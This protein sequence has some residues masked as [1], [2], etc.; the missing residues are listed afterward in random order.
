VA[1]T[2]DGEVFTFGSSSYGQLGHGDAEGMAFPMVVEKLLGEGMC[3]TDAAC[4]W[5]HTII[6]LS[7]GEM[8]T[9]GHGGYGQLGHGNTLNQMSPKGVASLRSQK[10]VF[11]NAGA[12]HT[13]AI[14]DEGGTTLSPEQQDS[15]SDPSLPAAVDPIPSAGRYGLS[16]MPN[17]TTPTT[18]TE[19]DDLFAMRQDSPQ[20]WAA[21]VASK[22]ESP[23]SNEVMEEAV[24]SVEEV[25]EG[26][27]DMSGKE[28]FRDDGAVSRPEG[29]Q[30]S[31]GV[32]TK[33]R[34]G[35][36][37]SST[38][39]GKAY[40]DVPATEVTAAEEKDDSHNVPTLKV[41]TEVSPINF[42]M[43]FDDA[44]DDGAFMTSDN[45]FA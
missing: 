19:E 43:D 35:E 12:W 30:A 14:T 29:D 7:T 2:S 22:P 21:Q 25:S 40:E 1:L 16:A 27:T 15:L 6:L 20:S 24:A 18:T 37:P 34:S 3:A 26:K 32:D 28:D 4:G 17:T 5:Y 23:Q 33:A 10:T 44:D 13:V 9:W 41:P 42:T 38:E 39:G 11:I 45:P 31:E 8:A 36:H